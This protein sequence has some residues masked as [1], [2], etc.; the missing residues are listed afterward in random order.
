MAIMHREKTMKIEVK[1]D[2]R[3]YR[4]P[5]YVS[6]LTPTGSTVRIESRKLKTYRNGLGL[7]I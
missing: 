5:V 1:E 4:V 2:G 3:M 7:V 6:A